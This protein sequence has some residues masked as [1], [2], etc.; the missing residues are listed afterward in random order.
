MG[1]DL[2]I[3][4][5]SLAGLRAA[6]TARM[7]GYDGTIRLIGEESDPPY[8]RP[9]LSKSFLVNSSAPNNLALHPPQYFADLNIDLILGMSAVKLAKTTNEVLLSNGRTM[10]FDSLVIATGSRPRVPPA[11][12]G[13]GLPGVLHL[14]TF[15]DAVRLRRAMEASPKVVLIGAGFINSEVASACR[16]RGLDTT[17]VESNALPFRQ[18][19]GAYAGDTI[20]RMH[21]DNGVKMHLGSGVVALRGGCGVEEVILSNGAHL[22]ADLVVVG[23]GVAPNTEWL[24]GSGVR[25]SD[26]V[27]VDAF[28]QSSRGRIATV[29]D[30]ARWPN[31]LYKH[32]VRTEHWTNAGAQARVGV[33]NLL[34][35]LARE[36]FRSTPYFWSDLYSTRV[37]VLGVAAGR[38]LLLDGGKEHRRFVGAYLRND[39]LVGVVGL[40]R[41]NQIMKYR[42]LIDRGAH[43]CEAAGL[44]KT[45]A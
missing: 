40:D 41:Q 45:L 37:Q 26:G 13:T 42:P 25:V 39:R 7:H 31:P 8:N 19:F 17:I 18:Q 9:E 15:G 2:V 34:D 29:G 35:P 14:R 22:R 32:S 21:S 44:A 43:A 1:R 30:V 12:E 27:V 23:T 24:E 36:P 16:A 38:F 20:M 10:C 5:A 11:L 3:V 33:K 28:L 4:G 6:E